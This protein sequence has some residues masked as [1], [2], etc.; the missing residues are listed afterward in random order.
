MADTPPPMD[1]EDDKEAPNEEDDESPFL[2]PETSAMDEIQPSQVV[3]FD[4][5]EDEP[6]ELPLESMTVEEKVVAPPPTL[7]AQA[8]DEEEVRVQPKPVLPV[9]ET[10]E[11]FEDPQPPV[12]KE[13]QKVSIGKLWWLRPLATGPVDYMLHYISLLWHV[14]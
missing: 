9:S 8:A 10:L 13:T 1:F 11:L 4:L 3:D 6:E 2:D 5:N 14:Q 12:V 7:E